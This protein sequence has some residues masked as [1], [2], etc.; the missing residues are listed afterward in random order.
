MEGAAVKIIDF[1]NGKCESLDCSREFVGDWIKTNHNPC[2]ICVTYKPE[3]SY[4][5]KLVKK[6]LIPT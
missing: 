2:S 3:C 5:R 4:Y 6:R 1:I